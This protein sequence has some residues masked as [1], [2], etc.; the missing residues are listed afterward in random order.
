MT[1]AIVEYKYYDTI[2]LSLIIVSTIL[3]TLDNPLNDPKSSLSINLGRID[4][5][6]TA[7]FTLECV[8]NIILLGF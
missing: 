7:A 8:I 6:M 1:K 3:L 2:V 5:F 4:Y